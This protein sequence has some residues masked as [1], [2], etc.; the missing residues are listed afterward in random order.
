MHTVAEFWELYRDA[1]LASV[2]PRTASGYEVAWRRRVRESFGH[3]ALDSI[4]TFEIEAVAATWQIKYSTKRDALACL[5]KIMRAAVKAG[6]VPVNP[7]RGVEL[8]R[9]EEGDPTGRALSR[10]EVGR[11][12]AV[13]PESGPYRRFVV[14]M[15]FTGMRIGEVAALAVADCDLEAGLIRV[16]KTASPGRRGELVVGPTKN[17]KT[18]L[19]PIANQLRPVVEEACAGKTLEDRAF[20]GPQGGY[21]NSKNLSRALKWPQIRVTVKNFPPSEAPLHWH[22][23]R[24]TA[25]TN[26]ALGGLVMPD[27]MA[28]AGHSTLQVTQR[29]LNTKADAAK[30]AASIQ[31]DFYADFEVTPRRTSEGGEAASSPALQGF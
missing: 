1:I 30:R 27:L 26:L 3:R 14:A 6:L 11:L 19:V 16:S 8:G 21:I 31:S 22:D 5:S 25:L 12:L 2:R 9:Q 17:G 23:L 18:R 10:A 29:Y 7:C 13:L 4:T 24:H 20:P 28:V 15:L